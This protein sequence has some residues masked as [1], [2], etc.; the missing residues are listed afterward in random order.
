ML[1]LAFYHLHSRNR[2]FLARC[3]QL[4]KFSIYFCCLQSKDLI[5]IEWLN[6]MI[7][8]TNECL[9]DKIKFGSRLCNRRDTIAPPVA[10]P[11]PPFTLVQ[12]LHNIIM[13]FQN[14]LTIIVCSINCTARR[15]VMLLTWDS[16]IKTLFAYFWWRLIPTHK[17]I[18]SV[19]SA[20]LRYYLL[21]LIQHFWL[22]AAICLRCVFAAGKEAN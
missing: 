3:G 5:E 19:W 6:V 1:N 18:S 13:W 20:R 15:Y 7:F 14:A 10:Y 9:A 12:C 11:A 8:K 22:F 4:T 16:L 2:Q 17:R 21:T